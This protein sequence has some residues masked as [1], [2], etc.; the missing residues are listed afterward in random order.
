[1][2]V[3]G[4]SWENKQEYCAIHQPVYVVSH[5]GAGSWVNGLASRDRSRLTGS[6]S[7]LEACLQPCAVQSHRCCGSKSMVSLKRASFNTT[8]CVC[9]SI[10]DNPQQAPEAVDGRPHC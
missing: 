10:D 6:G 5:C 3:S 8:L 1:V 2:P 4:K 9:L 7:A